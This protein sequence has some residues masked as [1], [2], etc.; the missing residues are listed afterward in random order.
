MRPRCSK[1]MHRAK[2]WTVNALSG[3]LGVRSRGADT[4][5]LAGIAVLQGFSNQVPKTGSCV[6]SAMTSASGA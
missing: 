6:R 5:A 1:A 2:S 4:D 3:G